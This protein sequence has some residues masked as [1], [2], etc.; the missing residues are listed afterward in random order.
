[1]VKVFDRVAARTGLRDLEAIEAG[2]DPLTVSLTSWDHK[3]YYPGAKKL[4]IRFTGERSRS[5]DRG[6]T[7]RSSAVGGLKAG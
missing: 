1:M 7:G 4:H 5:V 3:A 6:A 2:F